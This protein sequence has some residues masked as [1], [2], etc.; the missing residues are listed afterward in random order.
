MLEINTFV[1]DDRIADGNSLWKYTREGNIITGEGFVE[2]VNMKVSIELNEK[3][4]PKKMNRNYRDEVLEEIIYFYDSSDR[5]IKKEYYTE[6]GLIAVET[7]E[8]DN[9]PG[10][11]SKNGLPR[12]YNIY[13]NNLNYI[14]NLSKSIKKDIEI[15]TTY[16]KNYTNE[17]NKD[18]YPI[19]STIKSDGN[20]QY[21]YTYT[22]EY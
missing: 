10:S 4:L 6:K 8:Y 19:A 18:G 20:D 15:G 17:Y 16:S 2:P 22:T 3:E 12:W 9:S 11:F 5:L 7:F 13:V 14:N 1:T 21:T